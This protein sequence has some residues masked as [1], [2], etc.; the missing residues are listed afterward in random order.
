MKNLKN[1]IKIKNRLRKSNIIKFLKYLNVIKYNLKMDF[2]NNMNIGSIITFI[3]FIAILLFY[4]Y[5]TIQYFIV[6]QPINN[7]NNQHQYSTSQR[8]GN[9]T[10]RDENC[11][12]CTDRFKHPVELDCG[13]A[14]C[15]KC[16]VDYYT[17]NG[18]R[19]LKC[20]LC[21]SDVKIINT[22]GLEKTSETQSFYD[23]IVRFN[24]KNIGG[25]NFVI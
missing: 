22:E 20:P 17:H 8:R 25:N 5:N 10:Q 12:I 11:S 24:H 13:H 21:R 9:Q 19:D 3:I 14:F 6:K 23:E 18:R 2:L 15:G 4:L 16:I 1:L 7:N